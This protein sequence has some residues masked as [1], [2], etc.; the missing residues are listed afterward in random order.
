MRR[1]VPNSSSGESSL[2][3]RLKAQMERFA[4]IDRLLSDPKVASSPGTSATLLRERGKILKIVRPYQR[5]EEVRKNLAGVE[6]L[7]SLPDT[8]GELKEM[9]RKEKEDLIKEEARL[10]AALE[11]AFSPDEAEASRSAILE[12]R[13]GTGGG[14]AALFASEILRMY[15]R[16]AEHKGWPAEIVESTETDLGGTKTAVVSI[17]G[18]GAFRHLRYESGVHRVQRVPRTEAQGRIHTSTC[19]VAVMPQAEEVDIVIRPEEIE[20]C[21]ARAS[22]PGG[23]HVNK[24][25]SAIRILHKATGI[26]VHSQTDR[27]QHRNRELA[28]KHLRAKLY[29]MEFQKKREEREDMRRS[30][31]GTAERSEKIRTY[32]F[33]QNRITDHRIGFTTHR[34]AEVLDGD[35]DELVGKLREAARA[36]K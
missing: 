36:V 31:I 12:V 1:E 29:E 18:E 13:A 9:A 7:L 19:T 32:N 30:Q 11:A 35:L 10:V 20:V 27:S 28:F 2:G 16:Y 6:E 17:E 3:E 21:A 26:M 33:P 25:S 34:M 5:L 24:T 4:E 22:G 23:Q 15:L 14:E 8:D